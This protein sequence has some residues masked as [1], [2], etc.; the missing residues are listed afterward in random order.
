MDS[1]FAMKTFHRFQARG[2]GWQK[3]LP[4]QR[5]HLYTAPRPLLAPLPY[6]YVTEANLAADFWTVRLVQ[7]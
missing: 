4:D 3:D 1:R 2:Y 5:D 7:A 6:A